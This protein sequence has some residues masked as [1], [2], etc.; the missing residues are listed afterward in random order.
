MAGGAAGTR[1]TELD[2]VDAGVGKKDWG[3][4]VTDDN[5]VLVVATGL[6]FS[7]GDLIG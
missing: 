3:F 4:V 5:V 2:A 6:T 1:N 7:S